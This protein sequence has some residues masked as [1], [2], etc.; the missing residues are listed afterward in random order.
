[1]ATAV[2]VVVE[3]V[4]VHICYGEKRSCVLISTDEEKGLLSVLKSHV[5]IKFSFADSQI[6][7]PQNY[8]NLR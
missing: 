5:V 4:I 7:L 2:E 1:M 6:L 3:G 8:D